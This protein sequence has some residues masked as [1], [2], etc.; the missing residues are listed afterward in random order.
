MDAFAAHY[1]L[2]VETVSAAMENEFFPLPRRCGAMRPQ[3]IGRAEVLS[4]C[5]GFV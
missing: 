5:P 4:F 2:K 3:V 1:H